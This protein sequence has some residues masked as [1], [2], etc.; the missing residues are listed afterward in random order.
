MKKWVALFAVIGLVGVVWYIVRQKRVILDIRQPKTEKID[1]GDI[2]VPITA[3][4]RIEPIQRFEVKSKAGGEVIEIKVEPGDY[5]HKD[6]VLVLLDPDLEARNLK[7]AKSDLAIAK[8]QLEDAGHK[9]ADAEQQV[10]IN[11]AT[12]EGLVAT[13]ELLKADYERVRA[14]SIV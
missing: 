14:E 10:T 12:L 3:P 11:E 1:R 13:D 9:V 8:A 4:G 7:R 6:D 2:H 5:V